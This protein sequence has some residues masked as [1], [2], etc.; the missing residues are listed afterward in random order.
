MLGSAAATP[1]SYLFPFVMTPA[2]QPAPQSQDEGTAIGMSA[3]L[4]RQTVRYA[5]REASGTIIVDTPNAYL[6]YVL[7]N[8]LAIRYRIGR[9]SLIWSRT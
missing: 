6:Y 9:D 1:C 3:R 8:G 7:D 4:K 2:E 5:T